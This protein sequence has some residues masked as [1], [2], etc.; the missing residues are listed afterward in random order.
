VTIAAFFG[1]L[2]SAAG[3][4]LAAVVFVVATYRAFLACI[5]LL[6]VHGRVPELE[7]AAPPITRFVTLIPAHDEELLIGSAVDSVGAADYPAEALQVWVIADNCSDKTA[8]RAREHG[9]RVIERTD[10]YH[11]GK[12]AALA[13]AI[14]ALETES[15]DAVAIVD[16]DVIVGKGFYR[17]MHRELR[18][19]ACI[20][21]GYD[22]MANP[23]ETA[24]TRL[25]AVTSVMKNL[26]YNAGK[27]AIGFS[28]LLEGKGM[29]FRADVLKQEGWK[30]QGITEDHEQSLMLISQGHRVRFVA[31]APVYAQEATTLRQA[32]TQ[33]E[34][35]SSGRHQLQRL[36]LHIL[37]SALGARD[38]V[39]AEAAF[40][41]LCP[42]YSMLL[43]WNGVAL[44][45]LGAAFPLLPMVPLWPWVL[46]TTALA[47]QVGEFALGLWVMKA[48]RRY[49]Y[50][51]AFAP[52]FLA[53]KALVDLRS[54]LWG[55]RS[56]WIRTERRPHG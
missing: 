21:Q 49:T 2:F 15:C 24:L 52:V 56:A 19:G 37:V 28:P 22:G 47:L 32:R 35:W 51:V 55:G 46:A 9:A 17:A 54:A 25:I 34:R 27:S 4:L 12:G 39:A 13:F 38:W 53:W 43:N 26:L 50:S 5:Y 7:P 45:F 6:R 40:G 23:D 48:S 31:D 18:A 33:R 30:A 44:M 29:V 14:E 10:P 8:D 11:R 42:N 20:L 16:A 1:F 36:A 41:L 3:A